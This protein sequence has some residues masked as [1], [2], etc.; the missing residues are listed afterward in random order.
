[1]QVSIFGSALSGNQGAVAMMNSAVELIRKSDPL[2]EITLH[3]VYPKNDRQANVDKK[4]QIVNSEP[5]RLILQ[6]IPAA[7]LFRF[8]KPVRRFL[9]RK[10]P[11]LDALVKSDLLLDQMG[12]SFM[13]GREKFL[14]YNL[15]GVF[16][17]L[18][19]GVPIVKA[20]QAMGPFKNPI[21]RL[22]ATTILPKF[23]SIIAR[24]EKSYQH[25]SDLKLSNIRLGAD[26]VFSTASHSSVTKTRLSAQDDSAKFRRATVAVAPSSVVF[27]LLDRRGAG[28]YIKLLVHQIEVI[29]ALGYRAIVLPFSSKPDSEQLHNNDLPICRKL[30]AAI[31][32]RDEL[33]VEVI[34][35]P[36]SLPSAIKIIEESEFVVT[37]RFHAMV[38]ALAVG[39][40]PIVIAWGHKYD[41]V[42]EPFG[43]G[44]KVIPHESVTTERI[45]RAIGDQDSSL[46]SDRRAIALGLEEVRKRSQIHEKLI[47]EA[48]LGPQTE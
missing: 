19:L 43:L 13:D 17:A 7:I 36:L 18:I 32:G 29:N 9:R 21:N 27:Q 20:A 30:L 28:N 12:V 37:S 1:M 31:R 4:I 6:I 16:P 11:A 44:H 25:L 3:S 38:S 14:L 2:A 24:G 22:A 10:V 41:E 33:S 45:E 26:I 46:D 48:A 5:L 8:L 23:R 40:P 15:A 42:M 39:T 34:T 35:E 47:A